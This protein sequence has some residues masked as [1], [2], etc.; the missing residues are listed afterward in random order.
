M[1][2]SNTEKTPHNTLKK[3]FPGYDTK[4]YL[5]VRLQSW[6][7]REYGVTLSIAITPSSTLIQNGSTY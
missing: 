6:I 5:V 1:I 7:F 4:V 2:V 3:K